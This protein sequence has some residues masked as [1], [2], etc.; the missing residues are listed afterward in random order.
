[1]LQVYFLAIHP[2]FNWYGSHATQWCYIQGYIVQTNY[3]FVIYPISHF[4]W[5]NIYQNLSNLNINYVT[6]NAQWYLDWRPKIFL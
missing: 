2:T 6:R 4:Q 1:M 5:I 3:M